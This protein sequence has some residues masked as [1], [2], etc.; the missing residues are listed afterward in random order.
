MTA[1]RP[2]NFLMTA[3]VMAAAALVAFAASPLLHVASQV[4]A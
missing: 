2:S 1:T 3:F 4:I